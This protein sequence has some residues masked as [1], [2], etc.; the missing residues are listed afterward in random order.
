MYQPRLKILTTMDI[1]HYFQTKALNISN[2]KLK[3][4][5]NYTFQ[6]KLKKIV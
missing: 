2:A 4:S 5:I 6:K 3:S 1:S